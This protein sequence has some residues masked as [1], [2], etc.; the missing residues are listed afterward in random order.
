MLCI[1][2]GWVLFRAESVPAALQY[3]AAMLGLAGNPLLDN[4]AAFYWREYAVMLGIG[5]L[6]CTP[7]WKTLRVCAQKNERL[8]SAANWTGVGW[9]VLLLLLCISSLVMGGNNPFI[10]FNF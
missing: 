6:C 2:A 4:N 10:Y 3:L 8:D 9:S 1:L 5:I 7:V